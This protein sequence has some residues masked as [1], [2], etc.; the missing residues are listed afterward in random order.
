[1]TPVEVVTDTSFMGFPLFARGKVRDIYT[2]GGD[3]LIV[4]TD[5]ISAFDVIMEQGIPGKGAVLNRLA[6]FWFK[7]TEDIIQNHMITTDVS[8]LPAEFQPFRE[9]L[10]DRSMLVVKANPLPVECVARGYLAGSGWK[11]YQETGGICGIP[12]PGGLRQADRLPEPIFTPATKAE[13]GD[14]DLNI[15][16]QDVVADVGED[17]AERLKRLTLDLYA[18]GSEIAE[19]RGIIL[20]DTKFEFGLKDNELWLIDEIFTPD[21]SR[22]WPMDRYEPGHDQVNLDKQVLRDW[23]ET[24]DWD[25]KPPPPEL[26]PEIIEQTAE[27][28]QYIKKLLLG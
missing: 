26:P 6:E 7:Q 16:F 8:Q 22:F 13:L 4:S 2:V 23:L 28:Y 21:S 5:R 25:K 10:A 17:A 1:L 14:H 19:E 18:R 24:L 11:D 27:R 9:Q 12:L 3:L 15:P 20:A